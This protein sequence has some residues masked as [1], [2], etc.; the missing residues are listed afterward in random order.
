MSYGLMQG[1]Y[2]NPPK[3][4]NCTLCNSFSSDM[5]S[6]NRG[7]VALQVSRDLWIN[8]NTLVNKSPFTI[9][10]SLVAITILFFDLF[11]HVDKIFKNTL[12][13]SIPSVISKEFF[14]KY[15]S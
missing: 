9:F 6:I 8:F 5:A 2:N 15:S 1:L 3:G 11:T 10:T 4:N 14:W 12:L 7:Y 13:M